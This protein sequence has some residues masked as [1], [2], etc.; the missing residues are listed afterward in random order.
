[1]YCLD[2]YYEGQV[3]AFGMYL[4]IQIDKILWHEKK[5]KKKKKDIIE[6]VIKKKT[7]LNEIKVRQLRMKIEI[8]PY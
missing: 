6:V 5:T 8:D 1:M 4:Y 7:T 2:E 3:E